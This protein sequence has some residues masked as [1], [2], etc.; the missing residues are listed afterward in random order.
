MRSL[1]TAGL[2]AAI[3][4][5]T[6]AA[7]AQTWY[8][9]GSAGYVFQ[10]ESDNS[11]A[12]GAFTTGNGAPA[13]PTGT[14]IAAGTPYGWTTEFED[15]YSL[16]AEAGFYYESNFRSG[17]ELVYSQ[18]D[19]D[20]H[21]G[22]NVAGTNID[23][24]DAAV[25]TGSATQLG[26]TVGAVVADGRGDIT[27][28]AVFA[29]AYYHFDFGTPVQPYIGAGIG[30]SQVD[31]TYAP[32]GVGIID[33]DDTQFAYQF[34]AGAEWRVNDRWSVYGEYAYR[35]TD[36]IDLD[37]RLFPGSLS[38]ENQQS[39]VQVGARFRF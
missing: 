8:V 38:I 3:T 11:G 32:S 36:D 37:N 16:S 23:G 30:F 20:R 35:A 15:G 39:A 22:V 24:V 26:A 18:A 17:I 12:T 25:L 28:T 2:V 5:F 4:A 29:N 7:H 14:P 1:V 21:S 6:G 33:G 34:K 31:V 13:L 10:N 27:N 19:V 9:G